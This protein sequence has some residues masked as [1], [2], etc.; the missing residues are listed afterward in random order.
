MALGQFAGFPGRLLK[1][2][3]NAVI[4][5]I[6]EVGDAAAHLVVQNFYNGT[7]DKRLPVSETLRQIRADR[8]PEK[9]T[10]PLAYIFYGHPDLTLSQ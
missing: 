4:G 3:T 2:G 1:V 7:F 10:T 8:D 9:T 6:W 5:P